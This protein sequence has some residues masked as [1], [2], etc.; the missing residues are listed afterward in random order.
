MVD[1]RCAMMKLVEFFIK[2]S[3]PCWI[4]ASVRVSTELVASSMMN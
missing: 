2:V 4:R 3:I 1:K